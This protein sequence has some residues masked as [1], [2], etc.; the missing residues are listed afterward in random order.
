M[1]PDISPLRRLPLR[2]LLKRYLERGE[3]VLA[4]GAVHDLDADQTAYLLV[5][6]N[7]LLDERSIGSINQT[8]PA[9]M[10]RTSRDEIRSDYC[11][12]FGGWKLDADAAACCSPRT[13]HQS[14]APVHHLRP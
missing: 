7:R 8:R 3:R 11:A 12:D 2:W 6:A 14:I 1:T 13:Q 10:D 5:T 4:E 9:K